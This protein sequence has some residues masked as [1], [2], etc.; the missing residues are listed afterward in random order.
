MQQFHFY[1]FLFKWLCIVI[2][3]SFSQGTF[4]LD[5]FKQSC[6]PASNLKC[7]TNKKAEYLR[8]FN[9]NNSEIVSKTKTSVHL[10]VIK[11]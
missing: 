3:C 10:H 5:K 2:N 9:N 4:L 8:L 6:N 1:I 7:C 11:A